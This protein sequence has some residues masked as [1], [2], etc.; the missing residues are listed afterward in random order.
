MNGYKTFYRGRTLDVY[1]KTPLE[2]QEKAAKQFKARK[3]Y[4][5]TVVL[6]E[7]DGEQ[8]THKPQDITP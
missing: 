5:V 4:D 2:A 1:A 6:C 8:V 3:H 7:L